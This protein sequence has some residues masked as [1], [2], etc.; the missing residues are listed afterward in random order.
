MQGRSRDDGDRTRARRGRPGPSP[1]GSVWGVATAAYQ[2]EGAVDVDGRGPSIWDTF[3]AYPGSGA[4]GDTGDLAC[5]HYH[6]WPRGRGADGR[7]RRRRLPVLG[8]LA[9]GAA[10]GRR[11]ASTSGAWTSTGGWSTSCA[12]RASSRSSPS[13]TGTCPRRWRTAAAGGRGTPPSA[14]PT[15]PRSWTSALGD[16]VRALDHAERAV[17]LRRSSD[18][19]RAA[20]RPAPGRDTAPLAAAHHLLLGHG[21]AVGRLRARARP[22]ARSASRSTCRRPCR[23]A[24]HRPRTRRRPPDGPAGQPAVHRAAARRRLPGGP[25]RRLGE[26]SDFSFLHDG[27]LERISAPLDFL[28]V[29]YYYPIHGRPRRTSNPTPRCAPPTTSA[30]A[31]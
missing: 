30:C 18:T 29:N 9:A 3:A 23:R 19:P 7:A 8:G 16:R 24:P 15:T 27:D 5:D 10:R 13:T 31:R 14:S 6:R 2:I 11:A 25:G 21:L 1:P 26:I 4:G 20:T 22:G 28:G 12:S 17:L